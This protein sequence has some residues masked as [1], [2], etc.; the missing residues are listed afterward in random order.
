[1]LCFPHST[2]YVLTIL[3]VFIVLVF[4]DNAMY[5]LSVFKQHLLLDFLDQRLA[6]NC[7]AYT[8]I[9]QIDC[10]RF[11]L[12]YGHEQKPSQFCCGILVCVTVVKV[13]IILKL[14]KNRSQTLKNMRNSVF[15]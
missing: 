1:M 9:Y 5:S 10:K 4:D 2:A 13:Q 12:C 7:L 14:E 8:A 15:G 6:F 11:S 3:T